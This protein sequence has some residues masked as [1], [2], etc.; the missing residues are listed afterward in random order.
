MLELWLRDLA[1]PMARAFLSHL[2][3]HQ[4]T[5][6][7]IWHLHRVLSEEWQILR[8]LGWFVGS[9]GSH[10]LGVPASGQSQG[11]R[12]IQAAIYGAL[13]CARPVPGPGD[14]PANKTNPDPHMEE[15][16][17]RRVEEGRE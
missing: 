2:S 6:T 4:G 11:C 14:I 8:V 3:A 17:L 16:T 1:L 13:L 9:G 12:G 10:C 7:W 5:A 15:L